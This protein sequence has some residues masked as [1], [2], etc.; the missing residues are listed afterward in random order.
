MEH[1]PN[2][3]RNKKKSVSLQVNYFYYHMKTEIIPQESSRAEAFDLWMSSPLP[4]VT[5]IKTLNVSRLVKISKRTDMKFNM[6]MCWCI[7]KAAS[8][9]E[10]FNTL[11]VGKK[12]FHYDELAVNVIV[13]N[14]EGGIDSC[15]V[16]FME[17]LSQFNQQYLQLTKQ[18][19]DS[20]MSTALENSM[21]IGTSA[22][23]QTELDGVVNQYS[24][25]FN[26]PF[27][28]WGKYK[29]RLFK[30]KLPVSLQFHHVQ[31]D[32]A[33]AALFLEKVQHEID[34]LPY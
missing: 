8:K 7:G 27:L 10:E 18:A 30:T 6:L 2:I 3:C 28:A 16:P 1:F 26:N 34:E 19:A 33:Q 22:M 14:C 20:C 25:L 29:R 32:G 12:L 5:F 15:D 13:K 11:P 24:G 9:I 23:I 31:M 21:V 17:D 4:M